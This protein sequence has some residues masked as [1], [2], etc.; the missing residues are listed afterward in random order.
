MGNDRDPD[1]RHHRLSHLPVPLGAI[2]RPAPEY[3]IRILD[4]GGRRVE[5]GETGALHIGGVRGI[6]LF[7]EYFRNEEATAAAFDAD[8]FLNTGDQVTLLADGSR[9]ALPIASRTC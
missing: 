4:S 2:G 9:S 7:K 3:S 6:S 5:R 1:A 8:G